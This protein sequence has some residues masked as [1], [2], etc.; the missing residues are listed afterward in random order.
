VK[1]RKSQWK[2]Q[3]PATCCSTGLS[4][5]GPLFY[6]AIP[7]TYVRVLP[8]PFTSTWQSSHP[9]LA[10]YVPDLRISLTSCYKPFVASRNAQLWSRDAS[11]HVNNKST[12]HFY[13]LFCDSFHLLGMGLWVIFRITL[14]MGETT[15][16][17][18]S[19]LKS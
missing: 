3:I 17:T 13:L 9:P 7:P 10:W 1:I 11:S 5:T 14:P 12:W 6:G 19:L 4:A 15:P 16:I 2:R 8:Y 18:S